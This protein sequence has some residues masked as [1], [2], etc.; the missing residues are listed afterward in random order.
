MEQNKVRAY[1]FYAIGEILLVVI[2]ILIALQINNLNEVRKIDNEEQRIL[3]ALKI[4][5]EQAI[6]DLEDQYAS[7]SAV[8][9]TL[10]I[11]LTEGVEKDELLKSPKIDSIMVGPLWVSAVGVPIIQTYNDLKNAG[12]VSL[13]QS[14]TLRESLAEIENGLYNLTLQNEDLLTVQQMR[15]DPIAINY[16]DF[17]TVIQKARSAE[18]SAG[19]PNDYGKLFEIRELKNTFVAKYELLRNGQSYQEEMLESSKKLLALIESEIKD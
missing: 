19:S 3:N 4:D 17:A 9:K 7:A 8:K 13:I 5:V 10:Q 16:I 11:L 2:G 14:R 12:E 15:V 1:I 18:I 6:V